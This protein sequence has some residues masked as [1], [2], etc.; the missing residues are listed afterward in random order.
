MIRLRFAAPQRDSDAQRLESGE[1]LA[2]D[3]DRERWARALP[4]AHHGGD[5]VVTAFPR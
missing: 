3:A 4:S 5:L 2:F 1:R